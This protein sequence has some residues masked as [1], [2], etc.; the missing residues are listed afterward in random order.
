MNRA[1]SAVPNA[2]F[3]YY[4]FLTTSEMKTPQSRQFNLLKCPTVHNTVLSVYIMAPPTTLS[5][6]CQEFFT[7]RVNSSCLLSRHEVI[8]PISKHML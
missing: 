2:T 5:L 6:G 8:S 4:T 7:Q 1:L 3:V